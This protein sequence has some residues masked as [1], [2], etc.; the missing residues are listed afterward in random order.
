ML[1]GDTET[2]E[3][4]KMRYHHLADAHGVICDRKPLAFLGDHSGQFSVMGVANIWEK[5]MGGMAVRPATNEAGERACWIPITRRL[6]VVT[7]PG[8]MKARVRR[9]NGKSSFIEKVSADKHYNENEGGER[10]S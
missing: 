1:I 3:Q 6:Q 9:G 5:V 4:S 8:V 10:A 7:S 2:L